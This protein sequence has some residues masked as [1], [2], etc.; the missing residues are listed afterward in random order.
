MTKATHAGDGMTPYTMSKT[1]VE[2]GAKAQGGARKA[3]GVILIFKMLDIHKQVK[4]KN[5]H[6][7]IVINST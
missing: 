2:P 4:N 3:S 1:E 5:H 7:K 6:R